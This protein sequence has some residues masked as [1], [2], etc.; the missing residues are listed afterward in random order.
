MKKISHPLRR[1]YQ[2]RVIPHIRKELGI[3]SM[4]DNIMT[5]LDS[6]VDITKC[7]PATGKLREIQ[8]AD[9][10][11]LKLFD[12]ICKKNN[13]TYWL[14]WGTLL[15]A[16]RH[17][18]FIPWDD[19]LDVCMPW[20]DYLRAIPILSGFF[21]GIDGFSVESKEK[22]EQRWMWVNHWKAGVLIDIFPVMPLRLSESATEET[23]IEAIRSCR[24]N[25]TAG[26]QEDRATR[27]NGYRTVYYYINF[28]TL[29]YHFS[30]DTIFPLKTLPFEQ[31]ELN[32]PNNCDR[33]LTI[34][35][36]NYMAFPRG[37]MLHHSALTDNTSFTNDA[38]HGA[39]ETIRALQKK[40]KE[41]S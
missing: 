31:Y 16:V 3:D 29:F 35:Y 23:V 21:S 18:G 33:Y 25:N 36:K 2:K 12:L 8:L 28:P 34:Q 32:V 15:G 14:D 9:T 7:K 41:T 10:E 11:L 24:S 38:L 13:L 30:E 17:Q 37:N 39:L 19:D 20:D 5:V 40:E 4:Y 6:A 22:A 27:I 1:F 26:S